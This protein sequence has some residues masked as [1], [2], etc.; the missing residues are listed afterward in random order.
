MSF[1]R[2]KL[3]SLKYMS[4]DNK[5]QPMEIKSAGLILYVFLI[6]LSSVC[7]Q[8]PSG[9][10]GG[11]IP[12]YSTDLESALRT[13]L[14][15]GYEVLQRP[16]K[17]VVVSVALNML[18]INSLAIKD[19]ALSISAYF[20]MKWG[21]SRLSWDENSNYTNIPFLFSNENYMWAPSIIVE[22]SVKE[23]SVI[24]DVKTLMRISSDGIINWTPGGIYE[25]SCAADVT[26]YPLDTQTCS[27]ILSTWSYT[28]N[29]VSLALDRDE[30]I[31][32]TYY[33][34]NGEWEVISTST[35]STT[36]T[37]EQQSFSRIYFT[38]V[39][40]RLPLYHVLNT[41]FPVILMASLTIFVFKLP[42]ESGERIGMS[43]TV[44]L[45]YAVYLTLISDHIPQTSTSASILSTYLTIILMLSALSVVFTIL[46]LD[47]YFNSDDDEEVPDWL[48]KFTRSFL[49]RITCSKVKC[50]NRKQISPTNDSQEHIFV[51]DTLK[52]G[53]QFANE[54]GDG[55]LNV[56]KNDES[57][58]KV[59]TWKEIAMLLD[60]FFI[61][62]FISLVSIASVVCLSVLV[63]AWSRY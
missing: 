10:G 58:T 63:S 33:S 7:T 13:S 15:R 53:K 42:P 16:E 51:K 28:S 21:D 4:S 20:T 29:E 14:F 12:S 46:V 39:L 8:G 24:S 9:G 6:G 25:T 57:D 44:L 37:R 35:S 31:K 23:I 50:C 47:V 30:P 2:L 62:L 19:Q 5:G 17:T 60:K 32:M 34:E 40:R 55:Y 11:G 18:T 61:V 1:V 56:K 22:N 59:Y 54:N 38:F 27:I 26:Y 45:A 43:L 49:V 3:L 41:L 48:Q 52:K 36:K